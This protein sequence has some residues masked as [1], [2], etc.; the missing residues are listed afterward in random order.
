MRVHPA[1]LSQPGFAGRPGSLMPFM[2]RGSRRAHPDEFGYVEEEWFASGADDRGQP[3]VTTVFVRRPGDPERFSGAVIVEPLH[4]SPVVPVWMATAP[5]VMRS[6]HG[7]VGIASQKISLDGYIKPSSPERYESLCIAA[8]PP[9][10]G[11]PQLDLS[12]PVLRGNAATREAFWAERERENRACNAI[13]AQVGAALRSGGAFEGFDVGHLLLVGHSQ[14]GFVTTKYIREA[15]NSERLA[16]GSPVFDGFFP[17]GF[18]ADPFAGCDVPIIQVLSEGDIPDSR[19]SLRPGYEGRIYRR[20]DSDRPGDRFRLYELAGVA[21]AGTRN[22]PFNDRQLWGSYHNTGPMPPDAEYSS[23]PHFELFQMAL[24]HLVRWVAD[25]ITPPRAERIEIG[26]DGL[27]AKDENGNSRGGVRCVQLDVPRARYLA[28]PTDPDGTLVLGGCGLE[29]PFDKAT[30][31][32]LYK[33]HLDYVERFNR[34]LDEL[35][36]QGWLLFE[37]A[38][39]MRA[40]AEKAEVP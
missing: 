9:A 28:N 30:L 24:H 36:D 38:A 35:I 20:P 31:R 5:Y 12:R 23:L 1:S 29:Q 14:T 15:H 19:A 26:P 4:A 33:D 25:Q 18:P 40:E 21:H 39:E 37:D 22:P 13:L 8:D 11:A 34:R 3:Y 32:R 10:R 17:S 7:W 6:G 16:D 2:G 27:V